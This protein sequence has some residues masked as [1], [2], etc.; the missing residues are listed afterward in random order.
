MLLAGPDE[1][2]YHSRMRWLLFVLGWLTLTAHSS[3]PSRSV[4]IVNSTEERNSKEGEAFIPLVRS[5]PGWEKTQARL[6]WVGDFTPKLLNA[7]PKPL[8]VFLSGS[9]K[10]WCEVNREHWSG[11]EDVLKKKA[12][13]MWA[14][15]GGAQALAIL[16]ETGTAKAWDCPHCRD[17]SAPRL[18]IYTH[19]GHIAA[20]KAC[21]DYSGCIFEKGPTNVRLV[22]RDT[23]FDG[24]TNEFRVMESH[25]GQIA[26]TPEGWELIATAGEGSITR[27]QCIKR[28]GAP[29]YA[30]QFHIEMPG[31]PESSRR[32]M[33]NFLAE[34]ER[35]W[36]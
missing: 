19:L 18:P 12:V 16:S 36:K 31:T 11:I 2:R 15:C 21:G 13:P 17:A 26:W 3:E 25:C 23:A 14:S 9:F 30:A 6:I 4:L 5:V 29:I 1:S 20:G 28:A 10:D 7:E 35:W 32:I 33:Q 22:H 34:V 27:I 24:F 8:A